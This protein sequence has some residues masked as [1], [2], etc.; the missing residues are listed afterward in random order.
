MEEREKTELHSQAW[1]KIAE[2]SRREQLMM[3]ETPSVLP[4]SI[5]QQAERA[6]PFQRQRT[7]PKVLWSVKRNQRNRASAET[8]TTSEGEKTKR[9]A[10]KG[11]GSE[12]SEGRRG[13]EAW[14]REDIMCQGVSTVAMPVPMTGALGIS[15]ME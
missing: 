1:N 9:E 10:K 4:P 15:V 5:R 3:T 11:L 13:G 8:G 14:G 12:Y 6:D 2:R 7:A